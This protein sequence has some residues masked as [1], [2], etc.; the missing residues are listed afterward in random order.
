MS[1]GRVEQDPSSWRRAVVETLRDCAGAAETRGCTVA[2]LSL[3]SQRSSVMPVDRDGMPLHPAIMWQDRRTKALCESMAQDAPFVHQ[4]SGL[5]ISPVF[6]A[7]KMVW[8]KRERP[9]VYRKAFK[10]V[11]VHDFVLHLLTG[12]FVTDSSLGSRTNLLDL[13]KRD[14]DPE[15]I[16]LFGLERGILCDLI[17][18]GSVAGRVGREIAAETGLREGLPVVSAGGDQQCAALGLGLCSGDRLVANTGTG[19]YLIGHSDTPVHDMQ[20][21]LGCNVSAVPGS[22][23]VEAGMLTS[24]TVY[25]WLNEQLYARDGRP[26]EG[27]D[28]VNA[29]AEASPVGARGVI[30]LPYFAGRGAPSWNP[31]AK[32]LFF[33]LSLGTTRGDMARAVLEGIAAETSENMMI[34]ESLAGARAKEISVAGGLTNLPLYNQI[35][36]DSYGT[37]VMRLAGGEA[38]GRGAWI[39]AACCLGMFSSF[40]SAHAAA[41]SYLETVRFIPNPLSVEILSRTRGLRR[42]IFNS[43]SE[44]GVYAFL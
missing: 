13:S 27:F 2:G 15:L 17:E 19:S 41:T 21:R 40:P 24:G 1:D 4:R 42:A 7:I 37:A 23:I 31:H 44:G 28:E 33:N 10:L 6:S 29:D 3:T 38:T 34:M 43:L 5:T 30:L 12:T 11:G 32:G 14:W 9:D 36:A 18:P 39:S 22:Y 8:L 16:S 25:R 35:Q 26:P 20:M